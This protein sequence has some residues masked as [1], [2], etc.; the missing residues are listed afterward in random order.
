VSTLP[1]KYSISASRLVHRQA[2]ALADGFAKLTRLA[3]F[4]FEADPD[5]V[6]T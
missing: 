4:D 1:E 3:E 2:P 5:L 6:V